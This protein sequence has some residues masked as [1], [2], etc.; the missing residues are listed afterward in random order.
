MQIRV[1]DKIYRIVD[2]D[3]LET[4]CRIVYD[5]FDQPWYY[6]ILESGKRRTTP[7]SEHEIRPAQ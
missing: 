4:V 2:P 3:T 1:G 5:R 6:T 7:L